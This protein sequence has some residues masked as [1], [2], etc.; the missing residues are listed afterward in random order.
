M[1]PFLQTVE[2]ILK[3]WKQN[4]EPL[5]STVPVNHSDLKTKWE[6]LGAFSYEDGYRNKKLECFLFHQ[7]W[8][9]WAKNKENKIQ[10]IWTWHGMTWHGRKIGQRSAGAYCLA[11]LVWCSSTWEWAWKSLLTAMLFKRGPWSLLIKWV[12]QSK[13]IVLCEGEKQL[14]ESLGHFFGPHSAAIVIVH[15]SLEPWC[16][17]CRM[18]MTLPL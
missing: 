3:W 16:P 2:E 9:V 6:N 15:Q 1:L 7:I 12:S 10:S 5:S 17:Q 11:C 14:S 8:V 4:P 13:G 18:R